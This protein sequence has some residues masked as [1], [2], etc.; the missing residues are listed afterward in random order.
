M[1][2]EPL[3]SSVDVSVAAASLA[4]KFKGCEIPGA[5]GSKHEIVQGH[6]VSFKRDSGYGFIETD[7]RQKFFGHVNNVADIRLKE[8]LQ[9]TPYNAANTLYIPVT[10]RRG[11]LTRVDAKYHE[12]LEIRP[13]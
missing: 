5:T 1:P 9:N 13:R 7:D 12:A 11:G 10:F 8:I 4:Q 6:F 3:D 2:A